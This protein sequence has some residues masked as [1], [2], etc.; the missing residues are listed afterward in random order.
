METLKILEWNIQLQ[1]RTGARIADIV[2][3]EIREQTADIIVLT[4]FV[5]C[6]NWEQFKERLESLGYGVYCVKEIRKANG[7]GWNEVLIA[8]KHNP[9]IIVND[10]IIDEMPNMPFPEGPNFLRVDIEIDGKPLAI[11]GTRFPPDDDMEIRKKRLDALV[12]YVGSIR[13]PVVIAGDFNNGNYA[14]RLWNWELIVD[15]FGGA[16]CVLY[17]PIERYSWKRNGYEGGFKIDHIVARDVTL[18]NPLY[19]WDFMKRDTLIYA[20]GDNFQPPV[21]Y[22]DHAVLTANIEV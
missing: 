5:L 7:K 20:N 4:E 11:I 12:E 15:T 14:H 3:D 10:T 21:G 8:V 17:T 16:G 19:S 13:I 9:S 22:P 6:K 18:T 2:A 1:S